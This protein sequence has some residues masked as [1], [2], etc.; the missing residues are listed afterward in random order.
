MDFDNHTLN[1]CEKRE[2]ITRRQ[3]RDIINY[4]CKTDSETGKKSEV[5]QLS[6]SLFPIKGEK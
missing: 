3:I 5:Y 6:V 4:L 1:L 2:K